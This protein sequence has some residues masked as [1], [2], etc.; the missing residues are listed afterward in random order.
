MPAGGRTWGNR[1]AT[2]Y[3][4]NWHVFRGGWDEDWQVG[5]VSRLSSLSDGTSNTIFFAESYAVCGN[6]SGTTGTLYVELIWA[7]DGQNA[8]PLAQTYT[9]N[10][11][12]TPAFWSQ[13]DMQGNS[14][15]RNT[16]WG[17]NMAVPQISPPVNLCNPRMV[18]G[19]SAGGIMVGLADGSVRSVSAGVSQITW[20][21]AVEPKDGLTLGADW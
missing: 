4:A 20:G 18:Q 13:P 3:R 19:F 9:A 2:S 12:F 11:F 17:V 1:P 15:L 7:E 5:G 16:P 14:A 6:P 10:A 21:R 8:G